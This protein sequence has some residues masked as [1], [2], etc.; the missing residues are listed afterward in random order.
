[1]ISLVDPDSNLS[2]FQC[3]LC[4]ALIYSKTVPEDWY[5]SEVDSDFCICPDCR[6]RL[7]KLDAEALRVPSA[8]GPVFPLR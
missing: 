4:G 1:M 3:N 8:S 7:K 6:K 5:F 2:S